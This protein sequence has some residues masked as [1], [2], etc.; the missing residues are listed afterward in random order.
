MTSFTTAV[1]SSSGVPFG[2][3]VK[4]TKLRRP[5]GLASDTCDLVLVVAVYAVI[6]S[7]PISRPRL[8]SSQV[9][10]FVYLTVT[11]K[12]W[13]LVITT[14]L[15]FVVIAII[16]PFVVGVFIANR[17]RVA[18]ARAKR[19]IHGGSPFLAPFAW[20]YYL[21]KEEQQSAMAEAKGKERK[22]EL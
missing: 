11:H 5:H 13:V 19:G 17:A 21:T 15:L 7:R 10:P 12:W 9:E 1:R 8:C 16:Q 14:P 4:G 22:G 3:D 6:Q 18:I 20:T 2:P